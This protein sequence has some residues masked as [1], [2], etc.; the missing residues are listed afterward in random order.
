MRIIIECDLD[1]DLVE[2][3]RAS[4]AEQTLRNGTALVTEI[5]EF[6]LER[7][8]AYYLETGI[9]ADV[10]EAVRGKQPQRPLDFHRRIQAVNAFLALPEAASLAGASKRIANILRQA[11][12]HR[13]T[14]IDATQ[15]TLVAEKDLHKKI[16][17][18]QQDTAPLLKK[19]DYAGV[20]Q[21]LAALRAPV[22]KFFDDVRVMDEDETLRA[23]R[24]ALLASL[25]TLFM[26]TADLSLIQ[27]DP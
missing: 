10:F 20:L 1:L 23:N 8:R 3:V 4:L 13:Q 25:S 21:H 2:L 24:L 26:H 7:L 18:L 5:F 22:D 16:L 9:R 27:V 14:E 19:G 11:G 17:A 6:L 12:G 15:L